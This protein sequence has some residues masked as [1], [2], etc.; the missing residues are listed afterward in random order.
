MMEFEVGEIN[1][2]KQLIEGKICCPNEYKV[3]NLLAKQ[4]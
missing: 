2:F 4:S 3:G 1:I